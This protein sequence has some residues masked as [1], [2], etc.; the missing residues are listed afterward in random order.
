LNNRIAV[1]ASGGGTNFQILIDEIK[2]G[3]LD[4]VISGLITSRPD[5]GA[6]SRAR[7]NDIPYQ[8]ISKSDSD[9]ENRLGETMLST[10]KS[11][12]PCL[13]VLAGYMQKIPG[14]VIREYAGHIINIHPALL[15]KYGGKGYYGLRV[16]Q[17]VLEAG[18]NESGCTVH[19]VTD[20]YDEGPVIRQ[21][22]VPVKA[23]DTPSTLASRV[24]SE[25]HKLLP[26]VI[27]ALL[28][29]FNKNESE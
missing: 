19:F 16:H 20:N 10:L 5:C 13:I 23:G 24:L 22:R 26:A 2:H 8:V 7:E 18:E 21:S 11:W 28:D 14:N 15:P 9:T 12:D 3:N 25:E 29:K 27:R 4:A 17:A 6:I 1:L